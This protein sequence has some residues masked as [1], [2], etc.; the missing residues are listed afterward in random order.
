MSLAMY[1]KVPLAMRT[2]STVRSLFFLSYFV[3]H[4][5]KSY[6]GVTGTLVLDFW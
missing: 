4:I 3:G 2:F 1:H 6:F 5:H